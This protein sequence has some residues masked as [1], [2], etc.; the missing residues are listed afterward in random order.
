MIESVENNLNIIRGSVRSGNKVIAL[1]AERA[2][3]GD[4]QPVPEAGRYTIVLPSG[5]S[6]TGPNGTGIG[7]LTVLPSGTMSFV[8]E[9]ADGST[10]S[11]G[12]PVSNSGTWPVYVSLYKGKGSMIGW[13]NFTNGTTTRWTGDLRWIKSTDAGGKNY[14]AGFA[15]KAPITA[16]PFVSHPTGLGI[17]LVNAA[18]AFNGPKLFSTETATIISTNHNIIEFRQGDSPVETLKVIPFSGRFTGTFRDPVTLKRSP[19]KGIVVQNQGLC[20]GYFL[21]T[22]LSGRVDLQGK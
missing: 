12:V 14:P 4:Q 20:A 18:L 7:N 22:N 15:V 10:I 11:Q 21:S 17:D 6:A 8:A 19:V 1:L 2:A 9:L 3:Y 13:L 16:S 5:T